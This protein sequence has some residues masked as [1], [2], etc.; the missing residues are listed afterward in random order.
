MYHNLLEIYFDWLLTF[1]EGLKLVSCD[2]D[3]EI[4]VG[5]D[6]SYPSGMPYFAIG[7]N[8]IQL[9]VQS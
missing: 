7:N 9:Y 2:F 6:S 1:F 8:D 3:H 5:W 4:L